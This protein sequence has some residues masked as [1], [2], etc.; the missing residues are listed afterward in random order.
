MVY[1]KSCPR[2]SGNRVLEYDFYGWFM[3]CLSC[4]HVTYPS[5]DDMPSRK[6]LEARKTA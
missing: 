3:N 5:V 4:G 2:C 1:F 6:L